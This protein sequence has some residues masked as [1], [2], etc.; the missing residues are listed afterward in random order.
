MPS[1]PVLLS[2]SEAQTSPDLSY[3]QQLA[4]LIGSML[5]NSLV[6]HANPSDSTSCDGQEAQRLSCTAVPLS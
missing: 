6:F 2:E 4:D 5:H 1:L 3:D